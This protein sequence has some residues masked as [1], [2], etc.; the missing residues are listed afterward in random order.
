MIRALLGSRSLAFSV[1]RSMFSPQARTVG[2]IMRGPGAAPAFG[3]SFLRVSSTRNIS[4]DFTRGSKD[5]KKGKNRNDDEDEDEDDDDSSRRGKN[6]GKNSREEADEDAGVADDDFGIGKAEEAMNKTIQNLI[7]QFGQLRS[8]KANVGMFD[9]LDVL[10]DGQKHKF[11]SVAQVS[12]FDARSL[13]VVVPDPD[14][15]G[16]VEEAIKRVEGI[17]PVPFQANSIKIPIP[18]VSQEYR[19][20]LQKTAEKTAESA[21]EGIRRARKDC[22]DKIKKNKNLSKDVVFRLEKQVQDLTDKKNEE[23]TQKTKQKVK[24]ILTQ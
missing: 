19:E 7:E 23:I 4:F 13:L 5:R 16:P 20:S 9:A 6:K 21:K 22:L 10:I 18:R 14:I 1:A 24:E 8:S 17:S 3:L 12:I 2:E 15:R 11:P